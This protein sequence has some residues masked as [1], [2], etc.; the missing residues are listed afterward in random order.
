MVE[1]ERQ[2]ERRTAMCRLTPGLPAI[3]GMGLGARDMTAVSHVGV[4]ELI[5]F[6]CHHCCSRK[7]ETGAELRSN[8]GPWHG[9]G[10]LSR[11]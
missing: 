1:G 3:V 9:R 5:N 10:F 11:V 8:P 2:R 6:S 7:P 4:R